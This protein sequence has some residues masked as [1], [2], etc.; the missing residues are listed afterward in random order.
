MQGPMTD[1][2]QSCLDAMGVDGEI[3]STVA[4]VDAP[5][6]LKW[7]GTHAPTELEKLLSIANPVSFYSPMEALKFTPSATAKALDAAR[8]TAEELKAITV[9]E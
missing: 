5:Q 7:M 3:P 9:E 4:D 6:D 8:A 2:I 1:L